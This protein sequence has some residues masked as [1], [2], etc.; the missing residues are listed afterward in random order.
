MKPLTTVSGAFL[1]VDALSDL[2]LFISVFRVSQR[3]IICF[4]YDMI[5]RIE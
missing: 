2:L 1:F 3:L 5:R 4:V